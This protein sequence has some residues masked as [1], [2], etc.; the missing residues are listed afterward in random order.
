MKALM[1]PFGGFD[2]VAP[3]FQPPSPSLLEALKKVISSDYFSTLEFPLS[4]SLVQMQI[5]G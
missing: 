3:F 4:I 5:E 1:V 2:F